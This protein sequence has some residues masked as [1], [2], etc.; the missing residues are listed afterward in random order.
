[1]TNSISYQADGRPGLIV[2]MALAQLETRALV[3]I[4]L[5][6]S[7]LVLLRVPA[8]LWRWRQRSLQRMAL[9]D[10]DARLL[11]DIGLTHLQRNMEARKWF[12]RA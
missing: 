7:G 5:V 11:R 1:M 4:A 12:W 8:T 2:Q 10:L 9:R 6:S 3:R